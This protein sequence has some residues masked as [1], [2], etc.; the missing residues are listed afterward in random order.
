MLS[1]NKS[2][3]ESYRPIVEPETCNSD[4]LVWRHFLD[5]HLC[6]QLRAEM[7]AEVAT[8][9]KVLVRADNYFL[10]TNENARKTKLATVPDSTITLIEQRLLAAKPLL[11]THFDLEL[12]GCEPPQFLSYS[13]GDFF[14]P[15]YDG[16]TGPSSVAEFAYLHSRRLSVVLFLNTQQEECGSDAF[17]GGALRFYEPVAVG[18]LQTGASSLAITLRQKVAHEVRGEAGMLVAFRPNLLHEVQVVRGGRR[19]T[20]VSWFF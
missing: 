12:L 15:H 14:R 1:V 19:H 20:I 10:T 2:D 5:P 8:Q 4:L 18:S 13:A 16:L 9:A 11:E 7:T 17:S 6:A 3:F